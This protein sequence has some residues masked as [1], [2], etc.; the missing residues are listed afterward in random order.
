M[1]S[2]LEDIA[3]GFAIGRTAAEAAGGPG[4]AD[5]ADMAAAGGVSSV[6]REWSGAEWRGRVD[7]WW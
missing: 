1:V 3:L 6:W 5:M 2:S 4:F 7:M